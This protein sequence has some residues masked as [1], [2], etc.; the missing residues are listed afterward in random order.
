MQDMQLNYGSKIANILEH[1]WDQDQ[2]VA[3]GR[4]TCDKGKNHDTLAR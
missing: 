4:T 3:L 2:T 1:V